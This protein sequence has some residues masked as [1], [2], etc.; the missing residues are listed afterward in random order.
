LGTDAIADFGDPTKLEALMRRFLVRSEAQSYAQSG[1]GNAAL[2][3]MQQISSNV[4]S[5]YT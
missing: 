3:L 5:R 2:T 1:S 4:R